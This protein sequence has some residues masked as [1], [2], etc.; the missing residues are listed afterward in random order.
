[1]TRAR[2]IIAAAIVLGLLSIGFGSA[3]RPETLHRGSTSLPNWSVTS[4]DLGTGRLALVIGNANYP[5]A[6]VPLRQVTRNTEALASA[7]RQDGFQVDRIDNATRADITH[8]IDELRARANSS[9]IALLYF[10][11]Y[12][13]QS[14]GQNYLIPIGAK[15]WT[16]KDV[17]QE[18]VSIDDLL[19]N[20]K[21]SGVRA[22]IAIIEASRRNPYERRFRTYSRGLA[23]I[24]AGGNTVVLSSAAP[25]QVIEDSEGSH[26]RLMTA[27]LAELNTPQGIKKTFNNTREEVAVATQGNQIPALSSTLAEN[28]SLWP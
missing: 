5:D 18:G 12:G 24:Q 23:P 25:D 17:R 2:S 6:A 7:L 10:A 4:T 14:D 15:I 26:S 19:S 21:T 13:V 9:S 8:A 20:L 3:M 22:C 28:V 1:M 11:G 16:E 27:F